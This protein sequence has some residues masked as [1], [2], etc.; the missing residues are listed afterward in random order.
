MVSDSP[1]AFGQACHG[2]CILSSG[3]FNEHMMTPAAGQPL[4]QT[5]ALC[6]GDKK[7]YCLLGASP[8]PL[9]GWPRGDKGPVREVSQV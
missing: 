4:L 2:I 3:L 5:G 6:V 9:T 7:H 8:G 1:P